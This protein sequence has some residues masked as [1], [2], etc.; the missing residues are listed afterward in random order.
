MICKKIARDET[1]MPFLPFR[2]MHPD[3]P[4]DEKYAVIDDCQCTAEWCVFEKV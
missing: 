2:C 3:C 1:G 4:P